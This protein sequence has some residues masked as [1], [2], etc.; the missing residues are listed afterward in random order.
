MPAEVE[1]VPLRRRP[2]YLVYAVLSA[3]YGYLLLTFLMVFTF[4]ILRSYSP[5]WAFAPAGLMGYWVFRERIHSLGRFTG[6]LYLDKK[7]RIRSWL[8]PLRF[9]TLGVAALLLLLLP[10]CPDLQDGFFVLEPARQAIVHAS[11][12]G[13]VL[14]VFVH[15]GQRVVP[16][17]PLATLENLELDSN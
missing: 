7:E 16:G 4:N 1:Y 12:P 17:H 14:R 6:L 2:F 9:A 5:A 13:S 8:K 11:V 10:V 3:I 15:E